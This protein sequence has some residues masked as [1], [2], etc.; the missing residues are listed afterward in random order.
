LDWQRIQ[1]LFGHTEKKCI[2]Y[3]DLKINDYL[4]TT[5]F[6]LCVLN[7]IKYSKSLCP[8][9]N[10]SWVTLKK[11]IFRQFYQ[12]SNTL[13]RFISPS[14]IIIPQLNYLCPLSGP[15]VLLRH[16]RA[17]LILEDHQ[18]HSDTHAS[19]SSYPS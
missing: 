2:G 8:L 12:Q 16:E 17:T 14:N 18:L 4:I 9:K 10:R 6:F 5:F 11:R 19:I 3:N 1:N 13:G 7:Q 15:Y